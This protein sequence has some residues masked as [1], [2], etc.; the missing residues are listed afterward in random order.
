MDVCGAQCNYNDEPTLNNSTSTCKTDLAANLRDY[1]K[2]ICGAISLI[3]PELAGLLVHKG[4]LTNE[5]E[6]ESKKRVESVLKRVETQGTNA[7]SDLLWCLDQTGKSNI[8][9]RYAAALLRKECSLIMLSEILTSTELQQKYQEPEVMEMTRCLEVKHL[10]PSLIKNKLITENEVEQLTR[11]TQKKGALKLLWMLSQ[12]GPLAHLY[13]T[14]ALID[15]KG[16]NPLHGEIL[17]KV[18]LC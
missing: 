11:T 10:V 9:H 7:F 4:I 18:L 5:S 15:A 12:K 8:G 14:K 13:L 17:K 2:E 16:K 1:W 6:F 3:D